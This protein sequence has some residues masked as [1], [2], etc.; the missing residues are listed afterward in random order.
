M[1]KLVWY[2]IRFGAL[3]V[4]MKSFAFWTTTC[5]ACLAMGAGGVMDLLHAEQVMTALTHLGYPEYVATILGVGKLLGV[6]VVLVP[7][8]PR[9][10]EWAYAGLVIDL[11]GAFASHLFVGDPIADLIPPVVILVLTL[12]SWVLRPASRRLG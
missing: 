1:L 10:K 3:I 12:A 11:V 5:L 6:A 8:L 7:G 2:P 9:L 4:K